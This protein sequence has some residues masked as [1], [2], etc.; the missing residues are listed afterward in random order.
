MCC[1]NKIDAEISK[2]YAP[3]TIEQISFPQENI[4]KGFLCFQV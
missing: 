4:L 2:D 3:R 1:G